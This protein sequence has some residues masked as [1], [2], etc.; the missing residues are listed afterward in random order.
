MN[1]PGSVSRAPWL[2][3]IMGVWTVLMAWFYFDG[4]ARLGARSEL[5]ASRIKDVSGRAYRYAP[6]QAQLQNHDR[7]L[8]ARVIED[9]RVLDEAS[10][11]REKVAS[12]GQGTFAVSGKN[13]WFSASD[14]SD[15]RSNG[16]HYQVLLPAIPSALVSFWA[17]RLW[18]WCWIAL[19]AWWGRAALFHGMRLALASHFWRFILLIAL[20]RLILVGW[21]EIVASVSDEGEY[22]TLAS[23][24]YY[25]AAP[26]W[27]FRLPVYP[28]FIALSGA[29]GLPLR[30]TIEAVQ[31]GSM[32]L[33][34]GALRRCSIA[35]WACC[36]TFAWMALLPQTADWNNYT[37]TESFYLPI[38][39]GV[40][41]TGLFWMASACV[42]WGIACGVLLGL[43]MNLREER[44]IS[45]ALA[46]I[47]LAFFALRHW[48]A[49]ASSRFR[50]LTLTASSVILSTVAV[51]GA[52]QAAF[53]GRTGVWAHCTI[54]TPGLASL[55]TS[56]FRIPQQGPPQKYFWVNDQVR[57]IAASLS[58][59]FRAQQRFYD[60]D[61]VHFRDQMEKHLGVRDYTA[62]TFIWTTLLSDAFTDGVPHA[63][64]HR[65]HLLKLAA[66]EINQGLAG[67]EQQAIYMKGTFPL[68]T[69][70]LHFWRANLRDLVEQC[71][72]AA[73]VAPLN[74]PY[75]PVG[76]TGPKTVDLY[77]EVTH[78]RQ[79][80]A[81]RVDAAEVTRPA[82]VRSMWKAL[83]NLQKLLLWPACLAAV[84]VPLVMIFTRRGRHSLMG[85]VS[86][87][88]LASL[89]L[90]ACV[91][92]SRLAFTSLTG[93]Y[94]YGG[95]H[96]RYM[97]AF[98]LVALPVLV[99][100]VEA[101]TAP[102][103]PSLM[104]V[105]HRPR[106]HSPPA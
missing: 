10:L 62:D 46:G 102:S 1:K 25:H 28:L 33:L 96:P 51:D 55:M 63:V 78:R 34:V 81:A 17:V 68:N 35:S 42:S 95:I 3:G 9:G 70:I 31:L 5:A 66:D 75:P 41:A 71:L 83:F 79:P 19:L 85:K 54:S 21:D 11:T 43:L 93:I 20:L 15:P 92:L 40:V 6:T 29:T 38:V 76:V 98:T 45:L 106:G 23:Q 77:N 37:V 18:A 72:A 60:D 26:D 14:N 4:A 59:T 97:L 105:H 57:A 65:D 73:F 2:F 101:V 53:F 56:L 74:G 16:R 94:F 80:L 47:I 67:H 44:I 24:W 48:Q 13:L 86:Q 103:S 90:L 104:P 58:P 36:V 88:G 49:F 87:G 8:A 32:A 39:L 64:A 50:R 99:L 89:L 27:Y 30:L 22:V 84:F 91:G 7:W 100:I 52:F 69:T 82:W 61:V 12:V